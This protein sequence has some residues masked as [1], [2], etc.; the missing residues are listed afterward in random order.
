VWDDHLSVDV[1]RTRVLQH[2]LGRARHGQRALAG[3]DHD[4]AGIGGQRTRRERLGAESG[5]QARSA[6]RPAGTG[7]GRLVDAAG[8]VSEHGGSRSPIG[9]TGTR[10]VRKRTG[11]HSGCATSSAGAPDV[12]RTHPQKEQSQ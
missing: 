9:P 3:A 2:P 1:G 5:D 8:V 4:H 11:G 6:A 12:P 10:S 7:D